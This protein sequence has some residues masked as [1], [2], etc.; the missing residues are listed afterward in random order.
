MAALSAVRLEFATR[1]IQSLAGGGAL[2]RVVG[3]TSNNHMKPA[4][5]RLAFYR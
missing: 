2:S 4:G 5:Q 1:L 3:R